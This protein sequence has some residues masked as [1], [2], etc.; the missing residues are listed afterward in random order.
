MDEIMEARIRLT[1]LQKQRK[2]AE[3]A[4]DST[5]KLDREICAIERDLG[6]AAPSEDGSHYG[7][8]VIM[9]VPLDDPKK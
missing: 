5:E 4:G 6:S 1:K 3:A 2:A 7:G 9:A 8:R